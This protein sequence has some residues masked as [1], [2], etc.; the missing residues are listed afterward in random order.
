MT[1]ESLKS[2]PERGK[3]FSFEFKASSSSPFLFSF[4][5]HFGVSEQSREREMAKRF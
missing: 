3:T 1:K 2:I 4:L 5:S